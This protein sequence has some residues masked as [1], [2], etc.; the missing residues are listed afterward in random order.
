M[1]ESSTATTAWDLL[2]MLV[3]SLVTHGRG[4]ASQ[5]FLTFTVSCVDFQPQNDLELQMTI[6]KHLKSESSQLSHRV[7]VC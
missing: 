7:Y 6:E 2:V 4:M 5:S 1:E 3:T